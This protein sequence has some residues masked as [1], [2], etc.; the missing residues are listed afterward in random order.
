M[1]R[2]PRD[3]NSAPA[4]FRRLFATWLYYPDLY[5]SLWRNSVTR[6][7]GFKA[8]FLLWLV[9]EF[10]WFGLQLAFIGVIYS[11]TETIGDWTNWQVVMLVG[12]SHMIQQLFQAFLL[13]NCGQLAELV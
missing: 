11:H 12:A 7:L 3:A 4:R 13:V 8:N 10:F 2:G 1:D 5:V 6:E 9:V